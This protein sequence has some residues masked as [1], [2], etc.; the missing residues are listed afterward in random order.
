MVL[1]TLCH[2]LAFRSQ[3]YNLRPFVKSGIFTLALNGTL[4][5]SDLVNVTVTVSC[6]L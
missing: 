1:L 2:A 6:L 3:S 5:S 4:T